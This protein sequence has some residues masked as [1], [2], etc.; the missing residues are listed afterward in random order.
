MINTIADVL[1]YGMVKD[2]QIGVDDKSVI[3][4][5]S[6]GMFRVD[7]CIILGDE[8][9]LPLHR[10]TYNSQEVVNYGITSNVILTHISVVDNHGDLLSVICPTDTEIIKL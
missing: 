4:T 9:S 5:T 8:P 7:N 3:F 2:V 1:N 10:V 6:H